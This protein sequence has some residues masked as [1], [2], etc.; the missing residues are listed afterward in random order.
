MFFLPRLQQMHRW[1]LQGRPAHL[2]FIRVTLTV[3]STESTSRKVPKL[4]RQYSRANKNINT[5]SQPVRLAARHV[6]AR[7]S[8]A[9]GAKDKANPEAGGGN[10]DD[11]VR[12]DDKVVVRPPCLTETDLDFVD[13]DLGD[14]SDE[15]LAVSVCVRVI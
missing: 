10:E 9:R 8:P 1:Q 5:M 4:S 2:S 7:E 14:L 11:D 12:N 3:D 6:A 13:C 15:A